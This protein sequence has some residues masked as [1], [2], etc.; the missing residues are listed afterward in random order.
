M[1]IAITLNAKSKNFI[2]KYCGAAI[3]GT[4]PLC[5]YLSWLHLFAPALSLLKETYCFQ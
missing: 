1:H 3:G 5:N 4:F 2:I